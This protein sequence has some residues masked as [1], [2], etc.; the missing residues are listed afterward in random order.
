MVR[1]LDREISRHPSALKAP[2]MLAEG[3]VLGSKD[4]NYN[5]ICPVRAIQI[6]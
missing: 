5:N 3:N 4:P 2:A 1:S 6:V